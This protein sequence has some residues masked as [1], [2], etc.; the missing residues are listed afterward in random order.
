MDID[1]ESSTW[2]KVDDLSLKHVDTDKSNEQITD[3]SSENLS[4]YESI[5]KSV[6]WMTL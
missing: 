6:K 5:E 4:V 3:F 2:R 1:D